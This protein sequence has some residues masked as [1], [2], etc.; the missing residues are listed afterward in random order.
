M[1][2]VPSAAAVGRPV[3]ALLIF[4]SAALANIELPCCHWFGFRGGLLR[5]WWIVLVMLLVLT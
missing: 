5:D 2:A 1:G 3:L 4:A